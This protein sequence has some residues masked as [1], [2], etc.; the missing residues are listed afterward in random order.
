MSDCA[1]GNARSLRAGMLCLILTSLLLFSGCATA[2]LGAARASFYRG[3]FEKAELALAA[4]PGGDTDRLLV[5]M[6]R[7]MIRQARHEYDASIKDWLEAAALGEKLDYYSLTRGTASFAANDRVM[8]FR[9]APYERTLMR[10]FT[11]KNYLALSMW[12]DAAVEARNI[13]ARLENL[14]GFPDDAYCHYLAGVCLELAGDSEG[15]AFQYR[16]L[17]K[18]MPG[19]TIGERTGSIAP[20]AA[21]PSPEPNA[22]K[23][24]SELVCFVSIGRIPVVGQPGAGVAFGRVAPYAEIYS[25]DTY[26]GRTYPFSNTGRLVAETQK[27]LAALKLLKTT[28]RIAAKEAVSEAVSQKNELL[29]EILRLILFALEAPDTRQ[30]Q[31]LP[32]WLEIGRMTCPDDLKSLRVVFKD[33]AGRAVKETMVGEPLTRRGKTFVSFC[34]DL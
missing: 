22:P 23:T 15:A 18:A 11:A 7:G 33:G 17:S 19:L 16:Y 28:T 2:P 13:I 1:R 29:G 20:A 10:A 4:I 34:R 24:A 6:E 14:Y 25:H 31:T 5:Q 8:A 9:G 26:L 12:D 27:R 30:W 21:S 3:D 32:E